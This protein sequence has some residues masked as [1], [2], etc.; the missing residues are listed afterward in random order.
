[1]ASYQTF[2]LASLASVKSLALLDYVFNPC[3]LI[4]IEFYV[5][6]G[7]YSA[8]FQSISRDSPLTVQ[9]V[10][11]TVQVSGQV[12]SFQS[13]RSGS[14]VAPYCISALIMPVGAADC[15]SVDLGQKTLTPTASCS[16]TPKSAGLGWKYALRDYGTISKKDKAW[17]DALLKTDTVVAKSESLVGAIMGYRRRFA[18]EGFS[19]FLSSVSAGMRHRLLYLP[20]IAETNLQAASAMLSGEALL[21][22]L[23]FAE[24]PAGTDFLASIQTPLKDMNVTY[25]AGNQGLMNSAFSYLPRLSNQYGNIVNYMVNETFTITF[26][27]LFLAEFPTFEFTTPKSKSS[28]FKTFL[29][30]TPAG[31]PHPAWGDKKPAYHLKTLYTYN[32][33]GTNG[34][35]GHNI[36]FVF[37][38]LNT[39]LVP[40]G[41]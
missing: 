16:L 25:A 41:G 33:K 18:Q 20:F 14:P 3:S 28:I 39:D 1:M 30:K 23:D 40:H 7:D 2:R 11:N 35:T 38:R 34:V 15:L 37:G 21:G 8:Y 31:E 6:A 10:L 4:S 24:P 13:S 36:Q 32:D 26:S 27:E 9:L 17:S 22:D 19:S 12:M 5:N 29:L